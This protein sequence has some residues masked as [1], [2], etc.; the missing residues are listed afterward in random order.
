MSK[1]VLLFQPYYDLKGHFKDFT[2][3]F[4]HHLTENNIHCFEILGR[5]SEIKG[6]L[7]VNQYLYNG[8]NKAMRILSTYTGLKK[9]K[10]VSKRNKV[11]NIH[12]LDFEIVI[13]SFFLRLNQS[14]FSDKKLVFTLHSI[15]Y[16]QK[17]GTGLF[18][19]FYRKQIIYSY[20]YIDSKFSFD[21]VTNGK[22]LTD[23]FNSEV[24][25]KRNRVITSSW[26]TKKVSAD[27]NLSTKKKN[28]FLFLGIIRR[29]K[30]IE[31][32]LNEFS[33]VS[34]DFTLTIAGVPSGYDRNVLTA[35]INESGIPENR[36][37]THLRFLDEK[38][39]E[40]LLA[41]NKYIV[42]PYKKE[43]R[44]SSGPLIQALQYNVIPIASDYGERAEIIRKSN[45]GYTF[46]FD[47][48]IG[49][50]EIVN[51]ILDG[52]TNEEKIFKNIETY[53]NTFLWEN[54]IE[55]LIHQFDVYSS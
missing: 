22:T 15:N 8:K 5:E 55:K 10:E 28:S 40:N 44:S 6:R 36:I 33:K 31:Y 7:P 29:D 50:G 39:Y 2:E 41:E 46:K 51:Q 14:F 35:L 30:N 19:K 1:K 49:L 45:L 3:V 25:L 26:G 12:F 24:G 11:D 37:E 32:L 21:I 52:D 27:I 48:A 38:D 23:C 16:L 43:N 17:N 54:I 34:E 42:L 20:R 13:L 18:R 47:N 9:V 4:K 53:K